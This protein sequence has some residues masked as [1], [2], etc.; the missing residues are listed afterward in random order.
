MKKFFA[1]VFTLTLFVTVSSQVYA[2]GC[3]ICASGSSCQQCKYKGSDTFDQR[4]KCEAAGCKVTGTASCSTA[5]N[6]K[7]CS[8]KLDKLKIDEMLAQGEIKK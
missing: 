6:V 1:I 7:V 5:A 3:Y 2:D 4:K 8:A